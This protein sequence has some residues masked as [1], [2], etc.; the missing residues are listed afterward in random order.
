MPKKFERIHS[1]PNVYLVHDFLSRGELDY[2]D[3]MCTQYEHQFQSSFTGTD[4]DDEVISE[5]R[6][7]EFIHL[8]KGQDKY[9][10]GIEQKAACLVG[11]C[12]RAQISYFLITYGAVF[13]P[14]GLSPVNAEPLQ[15][16]RY[17]PTQR[18]SLHHD[19]GTLLED[20]AI[21]GMVKP[22]RLVTFFLVSTWH[23][24]L[25]TREH[26]LGLTLFCHDST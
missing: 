25:V 19:A 3:V 21:A 9:A 2:F 6:T 22:R 8:S 23:R 20:G 10:R 15:V 11:V 26:A 13:C 7:S 16:V 4:D 18:F 24:S 12:L 17:G 1:G 5:E 14:I